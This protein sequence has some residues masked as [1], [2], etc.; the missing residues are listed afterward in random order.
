MA[1][2][3]KEKKEKESLSE[4]NIRRPDEVIQEC[5]LD[6]DFD[7][8]RQLQRTYSMYPLP[9][10]QY[11]FTASHTPH[12]PH[13]P[14]IQPQSYFYS[15]NYEEECSSMSS[16]DQQDQ[17]QELEWIYEQMINACIEESKNEETKEELT[18]ESP[19]SPKEIYRYETPSPE[20][21]Q[22]PPL[23]PMRQT[24]PPQLPTK[25]TSP[26]T[27]QYENPNPTLQSLTVKIKRLHSIENSKETKNIYEYILQTVQPTHE[28][29]HQ[30]LQTQMPE[31][32]E[33]A[34][35][36]LKT[37]RFT[38]KEKQLLKEIFEK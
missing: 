37:I 34:I 26:T 6:N 23:F 14:E 2:K 12:T 13:T 16:Q 28:L 3:S 4:D 31:E 18:Q 1:K 30:S 35:A 5:L 8:Y 27:T 19:Q 33:K 15:Q 20:P 9:P 10:Y 22:L 17:D 32:K 25:E 21:Q 29:L 36:L 7:R 38:P 24:R 11:Q